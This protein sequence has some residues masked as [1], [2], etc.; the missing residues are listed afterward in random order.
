MIVDITSVVALSSVISLLPLFIFSYTVFTWLNA[1]A[2]I[3]HVVKLLD[4]ATIRGLY[5]LH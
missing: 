2:T 3:T 4:A 5:L 1:L